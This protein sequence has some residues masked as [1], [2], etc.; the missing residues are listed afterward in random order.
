[1][2]LILPLLVLI[3]APAKA[4]ITH[5]LQTSI[6]LQV[7][8]AASQ[9]TRIGSTYSVSGSNIQVT[10]GGNFGVNLQLQVTL[11]LLVNLLSKGTLH[12]VLLPFRTVRLAV[13]RPLEIPLQQLA[14]M[15]AALQVR[16]IQ[17]VA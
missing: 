10:T 15:Q 17:Q 16:S 14:G 3:A 5:K 6:Q 4:D 9:A 2:W 8:G 7:D 12:R 1:M 13:S 11:S